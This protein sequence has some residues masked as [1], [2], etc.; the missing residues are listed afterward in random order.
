MKYFNNFINFN[1]INAFLIKSRSKINQK[2]RFSP[3]SPAFICKNGLIC[4]FEDISIDSLY[5]EEH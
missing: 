5:Q 3:I 2:V 4:F 1:K